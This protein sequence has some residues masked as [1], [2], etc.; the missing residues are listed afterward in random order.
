MNLINKTDILYEKWGLNLYKENLDHI[1]NLRKTYKYYPYLYAYDEQEEIDYHDAYMTAG[2]CLDAFVAIHHGE[3]L[4]I[5]IGCPLSEGISICSE[6][7]DTELNNGKPYYFGDIIIQK[8]YWGHGLA[9]ELY[10]KH[11]SYVKNTG[12]TKILALLV[13]RNDDPR[14]PVG[15]QNSKLWDS[16]GFRPTKILSSFSWKSYEITGKVVHETNKLRAFECKLSS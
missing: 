4:G 1:K 9:Y 2:D 14:K 3:L 7:L 16:F 15:F 13:E 6:L 8:P 12:F 11:I 5:S 10:S